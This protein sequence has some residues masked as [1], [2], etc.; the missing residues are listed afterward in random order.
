MVELSKRVIYALGAGG[1][2]EKKGV[3]RVDIKGVGMR[4][5]AWVNTI[6]KNLVRVWFKRKNFGLEQKGIKSKWVSSCVFSDV[7]V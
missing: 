6:K 3:P 1:R 5:V 2:R 4:V 7:D